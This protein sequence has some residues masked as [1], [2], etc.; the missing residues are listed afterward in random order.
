MEKN[1]FMHMLVW[2]HCLQFAVQFLYHCYVSSYLVDRKSVRKMRKSAIAQLNLLV[3][4]FSEHCSLNYLFWMSGFIASSWKIKPDVVV[5][6]LVLPTR[7]C[8]HC[9]LM[10]WSV[11]SKGKI[12]I[13]SFE[14]E[15]KKLFD[16]KI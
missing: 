9:A 12:S 8:K 3:I 7:N 14:Y 5:I 16:L 6:A 10:S 13:F 2:S 11:N 1:G 4:D 15:K